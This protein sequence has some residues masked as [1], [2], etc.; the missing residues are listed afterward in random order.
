METLFK[1]LAQ[2]VK[3]T[4][5]LEKDDF[6]I[7]VL[8]QAQ[9]IVIPIVRETIAPLLIRNNDADMVTDMFAA[10]KLRVRMIASKNKGVEKRRGNQILRSLGVGGKTAANKAYI[11]KQ[12]SEVFDL[13][14]FVFGD[15]ANGAG[16]AI[17]PVHAAVL[18]SDALSVQGLD[19]PLIDNAFR[20][21]GIS[22]EYVNFDAQTHKTSSNIFTTRAVL[23]GTLFVQSLVMIGKRMTPA[24][25]KH[26]LLSIGMA[27][28]YGGATATTGT[29][30]KTHLCGVYWGAFERGINAPQEMLTALGDEPKPMVTNIVD[31]L[32]HIFG[33][34]YQNAISAQVLT[35]YVEK[36]VTDFEAN[37][38]VLIDEYREASEQ[39]KQLFDAWFTPP[40]K[41]GKKK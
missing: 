21:G 10:D 19:Q 5:T 32:Q 3:T 31:K 35:A 37:D 25:F 6:D 4:Y 8:P 1:Q 30:L 18:Y 14:T 12:A 36:R 34:V 15:S 39:M 22:E 27:G 33:E 28:C 7:P 11:K 20:Q 24:A 26:L 16:K 41:Q 40:S 23:P 2:E 17:Y 29:N 9:C 38:T 13:N